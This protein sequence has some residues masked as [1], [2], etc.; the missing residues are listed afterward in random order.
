MK[1]ASSTPAKKVVKPIAEG[2]SRVQASTKPSNEVISEGTTYTSRF[3][4]LAG[5]LK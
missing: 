2:A 3:K 5:I 1:F 4:E